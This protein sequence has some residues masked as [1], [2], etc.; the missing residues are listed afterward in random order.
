MALIFLNG[1]RILGGFIVNNDVG[2]VVIRI[3]V[4]VAVFLVAPDVVVVVSSMLIDV[5]IP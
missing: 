3:V 4:A 1:V 2:V 5:T